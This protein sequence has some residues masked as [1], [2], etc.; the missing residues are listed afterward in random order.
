M[1]NLWNNLGMLLLDVATE[2]AQGG[3]GAAGGTS[4]FTPPQGGGQVPTDKGDAGTAPGAGGNKPAEP[5]SAG[6]S[7]QGAPAS[8]WKSSLPQEL[9][10]DANIKKFTDVSTLAKSYIN[11]QKL[12][13]ADK[14]AIPTKHATEED[15][16]NVYKKLGL[17]E[18]VEDYQVKFKEGVSLDE[19][20]AKSFAEQAYK[21]GVLPKQA[22]ALADWISEINVTAETKVQEEI[23]KNFEK[24]VSELK[25]EWGNSF[26][27]Q[28]ARANK[29]VNELGSPELVKFLSTSGLGADKNL[30]KM[31]AKA[32][33]Q[34]FAEHKFVEGQ[35]GPGAM[36]P[37]EINKEIR[38]LQ[39]DPAYFDKGHPSHKQIV[40]E[41]TSLYEKL[42][43]SKK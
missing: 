37:D 11:A 13:G 28:L 14:I 20:F 34:L 9:Q 42:Y 41:V 22:Q 24:S 38:K 18:K 29:F 12:I 39:A 43:P 26:D 25:Q 7:T 19:N 4:F 10:E 1:K 16:Q 23:K 35:G 33:E 32:G 5:A 31:F 40:K 30:V 21:A 17:P 15:W 2:G 3:T 6:N 27:L 36:S 8:D